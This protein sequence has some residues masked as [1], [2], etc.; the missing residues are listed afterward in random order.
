[1]PNQHGTYNSF[2]E[3]TN[4]LGEYSSE[5]LINELNKRNIHLTK[6]YD[7]VKQYEEQHELIGRIEELEYMLNVHSGLFHL[8]DRLKKFKAMLNDIK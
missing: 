5:Q 7:I 2:K 1:M 8:T 3:D 4:W 6:S